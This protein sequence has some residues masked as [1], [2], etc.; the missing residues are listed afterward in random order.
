MWKSLAGLK[1]TLQEA[2]LCPKENDMFRL[3][4][5]GSTLADPEPLVKSP[6]IEEKATEIQWVG[7]RGKGVDRNG[8]LCWA[9]VQWDSDPARLLG[10][11]LCGLEQP[12]HLSEPG[13]IVWALSP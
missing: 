3:S 10:P 12:P 4:I 5:E 2:R 6:Q 7:R 9:D 8:Q 13:F 1:L 11:A